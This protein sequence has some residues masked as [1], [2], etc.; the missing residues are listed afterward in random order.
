MMNIMIMIIW[1]IRERNEKKNPNSDEKHRDKMRETISLESLVN[2]FTFT[3]PNQ[4]M[5][6]TNNEVKMNGRRRR[7]RKRP[8]DMCCD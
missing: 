5:K 8:E 3:R 6:N 4:I 7:V 1:F 2:P